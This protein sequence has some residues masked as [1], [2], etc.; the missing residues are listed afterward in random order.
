MPA[1]IKNTTYRF[2]TEGARRSQRENM[3]TNHNQLRRKE[4][5]MSYIELR[6]VH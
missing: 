6:V 1:I 4:R 5:S 2:L 3:T